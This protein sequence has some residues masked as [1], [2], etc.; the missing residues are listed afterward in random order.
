MELEYLG[1]RIEAA[2]PNEVAD[3]RIADTEA[4]RVSFSEVPHL[5]ENS[6]GSEEF[7][8]W[9]AD[10]SERE[11]DGTPYLEDNVGVVDSENQCGRA[12]D[13][14]FEKNTESPHS[15]LFDSMTDE[16]KEAEAFAPN[17]E[18]QAEKIRDI[19]YSM[20]EIQFA[21]WK[22]LDIEERTK[23]LESFEEKIAQV[24]KRAAM[25]VQHEQ[26]RVGVMGYND[27][28]KLVISDQLVGSNEYSDYKEVLN[29]LFHE[30]RHSYQNHN[31]YIG[32]TESS[33][34]IYKSWV[35][36]REKLGY[37]SGDTS[38]PFNLSNTFREKSYYKYYTQPVEVDARLFA[39]TVEKK[40]GL[41]AG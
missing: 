11:T 4:E 23:L 12:H 22:K 41:G 28:R 10:D 16:L 40:L 32:R 7:R 18:V 25:P 35:A 30:G 39:E 20:P 38:F 8:E 33:D 19:Y 29:T 31:L 36:N 3:N 37:T 27:G 21:E 1:G 9:K 13:E 2:H 34:E 24:E 17:M 15:P 5:E 6:T 26:T 14:L